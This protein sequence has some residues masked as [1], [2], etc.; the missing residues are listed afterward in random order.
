MLRTVPPPSAGGGMPVG[1][2]GRDDHGHDGGDTETHGE[3]LQSAIGE[4]RSPGQHSQHEMNHER[5]QKVENPLTT[6]SGRLLHGL[7]VAAARPQRI[8]L[9]AEAVLYRPI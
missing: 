7:I 9:R 1:H 3:V 6:R 5:H 8:R 4:L 2:D